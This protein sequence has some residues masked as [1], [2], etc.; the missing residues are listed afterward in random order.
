MRKKLPMAALCML[1]CV[2]IIRYDGVFFPLQVGTERNP[3]P[4]HP[5]SGV[6]GR[7]TSMNTCYH[8]D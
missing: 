8:V 7:A 4:G 2:T 5:F 1:A 6:V 3:L